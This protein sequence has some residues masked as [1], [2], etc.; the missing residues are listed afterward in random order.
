MQHR[1]LG[2][3]GLS[4]SAIV[5]GGWQ[6]G[7]EDWVG[8][9]DAD[10]IAAYRAAFERGVT[11][12]DTAE[13]YGGG[14][15][16]RLLAEALGHAR[17]QIVIATKV[18]W[19]NLRRE[20]VLR[21]C[22][23]SLARLRTDRIDLYQV[24]WPAGSFGSEVVPLEETMSA[25]AELKQQGK[26]RAIGV[27]NF[28]RAQLEAAAAVT[29]VDSLQPPYS[30]FWRKI[31]A[32][33]MP[34]CVDHQI[35]I[36]AYSPLAQGLLTGRFG[37]GHQFPPGDNRN[38]NKLFAGDNYE[39]AQAALARLR[40]ISARYG[41]TLGQLALAWLCA[42]PQTVAAAGA[43]TAEQ[44]AQNAAAGDLRISDEDLA[45][46]DAIGRTVTDPMDADPVMWTWGV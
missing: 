35:A 2:Q 26:I 46:I 41:V 40:P 25:L 11:T 31:E 19:K 28:N 23:Q 29:R 33:A 4:I 6:A 42:Q 18:S 34:Y 8:I 12:F 10:S 27:S 14:H 37:P 13:E 45:A 43:R 44:A 22:E 24:H 1:P 16:E 9:D 21:A 5:A 15:S 7:K 30:L 3:S 32:D 38:D 36:I 39:R 17:D 20:A